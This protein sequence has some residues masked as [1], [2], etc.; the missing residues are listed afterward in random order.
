MEEENKNIE[1]ENCYLGNTE[2]VATDTNENL[3]QC[4]RTSGVGGGEEGEG[5][6]RLLEQMPSTES[7]SSGCSKTVTEPMED[8]HAGEQ[9][10]Q[11]LVVHNG[12]AAHDSAGEPVKGETE[13]SGGRTTPDSPSSIYQVTDPPLTQVFYLDNVIWFR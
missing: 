3:S 11:G 8:S 12:A 10:S 6:V 5:G 4:E 13:K 9:E 2:S 1:E 7:E